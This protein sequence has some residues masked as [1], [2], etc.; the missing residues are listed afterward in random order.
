M[1]VAVFTLGCKVNQYESG[2]ILRALAEEGYETT[3]ELVPAD[4]YILNTCAVT[5]EAER[6]SRQA[7][8]RARK[9]NPAAKILV[10]GCASQNDAEQ[11]AEKENVTYVK[12]VAKKGDLVRHLQ[13]SGILV[14]ELPKIYEESNFGSSERVRSTIKIQDGCNR[15]CTYCLVPYLRGRSR[16]RRISEILREAAADINFRE[17]V[18]TGV[19]ISSFGAD[20]GESLLKLLQDLDAFE[21]RI[22]LGSL[23]VSL[24]T[25]D[26]V[27]ELANLKN[28]CPHFHLSLQSGSDGVLKKMNRHYTTAQYLEAVQLIRRFFPF[29]GITTDVIAGFPTESE[30]EHRETLDFVRR[31]AFSDMHVFP[32]SIR[33]G[34]VAARLPQTPEEIK[35]RRAMEL[36]KLKDALKKAFLQKLKGTQHTVLTEQVQNGRSEGYTENYI[37]VYLSQDAKPNEMYRVTIGEPYRDG[38]L[39]SVEEKLC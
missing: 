16:S 29:A 19:D 20:T 25:A 3:E 30:A 9:L 17:I 11:F 6:K 36:T 38:V 34:T 15:F 24:L 10:C 13:E 37:K 2:Q 4:F 35:Q 21:K 22:R 23:E 5:G 26:F 31:V 14:D 8:A 39:A 28:F 1:K 32:Y 18:L 27:R 12:G 33:E 7:V